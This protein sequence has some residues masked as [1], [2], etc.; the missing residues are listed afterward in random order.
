MAPLPGLHLL[1]HVWYRNYYAIHRNLYTSAHVLITLCTYVQQVN[2]MLPAPPHGDPWVMW[3]ISSHVD[4]L[5]VEAN[6]GF[7]YVVLSTG[8]QL[9][10][11]LSACQARKSA[12]NLRHSQRS[13]HHLA[14]RAKRGTQSWNV[15]TWNVRSTLYGRHSRIGSYC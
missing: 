3:S 8:C 12:E 5:C 9:M 13:C 7:V 1:L 4:S 10:V 6:C 11:P 14:C 2:T 15:G